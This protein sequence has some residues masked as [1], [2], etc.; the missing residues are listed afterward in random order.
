ME[1]NNQADQ[2]N[3]NMDR[4]SNIN[5]INNTEATEPVKKSKGRPKKSNTEPQEVKPSNKAIA[6]LENKLQKLQKA[7]VEYNEALQNLNN[8]VKPTPKPK[9]KAKPR[10]TKIEDII[11]DN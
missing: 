2:L 7:E 10:K 8:Q 11:T 9:P 4:D 5:Q 6:N 1:A 3:F